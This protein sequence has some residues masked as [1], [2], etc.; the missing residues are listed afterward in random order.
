VEASACSIGVFVLIE[1]EAGRLMDAQALG[2]GLN[3]Y[4]PV[5]FILLRRPF[6]DQEGEMSKILTRAI[7]IDGSLKGAR[8]KMVGW[9]ITCSGATKLAP[10]RTEPRQRVDAS[11][12]EPSL[13]L[14]TRTNSKNSICY[15]DHDRSETVPRRN[16][17]F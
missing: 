6:E 2:D 13:G 8:A 16:I 10:R 17:C 3:I 15:F 1:E 12:F 14:E 4:L 5:A 11:D 7:Y 9:T